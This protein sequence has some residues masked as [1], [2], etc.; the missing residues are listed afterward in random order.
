MIDVYKK[1]SVILSN[2]M[3]ALIVLISLFS[4]SSSS[5]TRNNSSIESIKKQ[6]EG[7]KKQN[8]QMVMNKET[9]LQKNI[10]NIIN[11]LSQRP[12]LNARKLMRE[13]ALLNDAIQICGTAKDIG[14]VSKQLLSLEIKILDYLAGSKREF[15]KAKKFID[16]IESMLEKNVSVEKADLALFKTN[17]GFFEAVYHNNYDKAN[18][19]MEEAL[20]ILNQ[21]KENDEEKFRIIANLTQF[22]VL[23]GDDK[24]AKFYIDKGASLLER[25]ESEVYKVLFLYANSIYLS[26]K[27]ELPESLS[28][29]NEAEKYLPIIKDYPTFE[30]YLMRQKGNI[31]IKLE[32]YQQAS[33]IVDEC[34]QKISNFF[35]NRPNTII[36]ANLVLQGLIKAE[37]EQNYK[38]GEKLI[39]EA[40][41]ISKKFFRGSDKHLVQAIEHLSLGRVLEHQQSYKQAIEEYLISEKIFRNFMTYL[42]IDDVSLLYYQLAMINVKLNNIKNVYIYFEKH[43]ELF[44][45]EHHRSKEIADKLKVI[46]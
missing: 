35:Q 21:I 46:K 5:S 26:N 22:A 42:N 16:D 6:L 10:Q 39:L 33:V 20:S 7:I 13:P 44:G 30:F 23:K 27:G 32:K 14:Y 24:K 25:S 40:I 18:F 36:A 2:N 38:M 34:Q 4:C 12:D 43:S 31:L 3:I 45:I 1:Q 29:I 8:I 28:T 41:E 11:Q 17:K 37:Y 15:D 19:F 9:E